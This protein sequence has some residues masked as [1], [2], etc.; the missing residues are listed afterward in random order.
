MSTIQLAQLL[1]QAE[2]AKEQRD[3][4]EAVRLY[5]LITAQTAENPTDP[6]VKEI[7]LAA[8]RENGRLYRLLGDHQAALGCYEQYY[9]CVNSGEQAVDAL[10]LL[11][12]QFNSMGRYEEAIKASQEALDLTT[13]LNYTRGRAAAFQNM[14]RGHAQLGREEEAANHLRKALSLFEQL[15]DKKEISRTC[16]WLGVVMLDQGH[17][18]NAIQF[19]QQALLLADHI[20]D[21]QKAT[22]LSNLGECHQMLFDTQQAIVYHRQALTLAKQTQLSS[23]EADLTRNLGVDL[24]DIGEIEEGAACLIEALHLSDETGQHDIMLQ[25]LA[26]LAQVEITRH[27]LDQALAYAETMKEEAQ[28]IKARHYEAYALYVLGLCYQFQGELVKA[29]QTWHTALFRAHETNQQALLWRIHAG[30][31]EV[32][33]IEALAKT[34]Y[35]IAAEVIDQIVYPIEN[36]TLREGFLNA[37][38]VKKI[39]EASV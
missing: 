14:G 28:A 18:D 10:A 1:D 36:Q 39:L 17:L 4:N 35:R 21:V 32:V 30:L 34:H 29:E 31:A 3:Y 38:P 26:S 13:A 23:L 25:T 8:L 22:I 12:N 15:D 16:N 11:A 9:L 2:T 5:G 27:H 7:R 33:G 6:I 20:S 19:F 24:A 37:P